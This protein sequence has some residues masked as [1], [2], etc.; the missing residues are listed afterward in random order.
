MRFEVWEVRWN[1]AWSRDEWSP[2]SEFMG[3]EPELVISVGIKIYEDDVVVVLANS[4]D[5]DN[6]EVAATMCIPKGMVVESRALAKITDEDGSEEGV[7]SR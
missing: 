7:S 6:E 3:S 2:V 5:P 4:F 1:D